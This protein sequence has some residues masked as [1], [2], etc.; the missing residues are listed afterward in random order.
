MN[1]VMLNP[2][3]DGEGS[4]SLVYFLADALLKRGFRVFIHRI[5][6]TE[7]VAKEVASALPDRTDVQIDIVF[8]KSRAG[9][10]RVI[11]A[12]GYI[13]GE[14]GM[15]LGNYKGEFIADDTPG[16]YYIEI[17][18]PGNDLTSDEYLTLL[19]KRIADRIPFQQE[20]ATPPVE[21]V[22]VSVEK[23]VRKTRSK[24]A[25]E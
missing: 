16:R 25:V 1:L 8:E 13:H 10:Y 23:P 15:I 6:P 19:A 2:G 18:H 21:V 12:N 20:E 11:A 3:F 24:K 17:R 9:L 7:M 4:Y 22:E 14:L 5:S